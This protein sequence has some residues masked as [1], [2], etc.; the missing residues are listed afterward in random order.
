M[1]TNAVANSVILQLNLR[2]EFHN[3]VFKIKDT[4]RIASW[5]ACPMKKFYEFQLVFTTN[6]NVF[7]ISF[8]LNCMISENQAITL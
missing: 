3:M 2:C 4:L 5:S 7:H 8:Q 1:Y 6:I